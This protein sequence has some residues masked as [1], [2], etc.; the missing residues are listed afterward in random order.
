MFPASVYVWHLLCDYTYFSTIN[1][2]IVSH[3]SYRIH[4][5]VWCSILPIA[6]SCLT[7]SS[8]F[9]LLCISSKKWMSHLR[10]ISLWV[11][12]HSKFL[13]S[14]HLEFI[15]H[16]TEQSHDLPS[17]RI[18]FFTMSLTFA[19]LFPQIT[20]RPRHRCQAVK[21]SVRKLLSTEQS[22]S[23]QLHVIWI[24]WTLNK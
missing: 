1:F 11:S 18:I 2:F 3:F 23:L 9:K 5:G 12:V 10:P 15:H 4:Y 13:P 7:F 16:R 19:E 20:Y 22:G 17:S 21:E 8:I 24:N 14:Y 6:V